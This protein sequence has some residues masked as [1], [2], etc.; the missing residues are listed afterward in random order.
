MTKGLLRFALLGGTALSFL[1]AGAPAFAD[2]STD[3]LLKVLASKGVISS[4]EARS[5]STAPPAAQQGRLVSLLRKKGVLADEDLR[6]LQPSAPTVAA[7]A[8]VAPAGAAAS[9]AMA[10]A[11]EPIY[12]KAGVTVGGFEI[13]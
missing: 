5:I 8:P 9:D 3:A 11:P 12:R 13:T 2:S 7:A 4:S 10:R 6:S 1:L